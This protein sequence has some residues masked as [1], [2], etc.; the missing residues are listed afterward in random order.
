MADVTIHGQTYTGVNAINYVKNGVTNSVNE[1]VVN[2]SKI[3][4]VEFSLPAK[5]DLS[6]MSWADISTVCKAGLASEYWSVGD[7]K[8]ITINGVA[9]NVV[10]IDFDHDD[11]T[12]STSYGRTKAGATFNL[13]EVT[14]TSYK[15]AYDEYECNNW[16]LSTI[17]SS[18]LPTILSQLETD[19]QSVIV[20]VDKSYSIYNS[21]SSFTYGTTS[22]SLFLLSDP[23]VG[24]SHTTDGAIYSYFSTATNRSKKKR[25]GLYAD[26]WLR[27]S[28]GYS[29]GYTFRQ[30]L[31]SDVLSHLLCT[32]SQRISFAFC[33]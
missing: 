27:S 20:P 14:D 2:G 22:D 8:P 9:Y 13:L 29:S 11:V 3:W 5:N 1:L 28:Y 24:G 32:I 6:D 4:E 30:V 31:R 17:R 7:T 16:T 15:M 21:S 23:E 33:V 19:L 18:T 26:W 10:L 25:D 12:D